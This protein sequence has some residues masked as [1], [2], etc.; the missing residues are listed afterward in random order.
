MKEATKFQKIQ[1]IFVSKKKQGSDDVENESSF[2]G[3]DV[4]K[5]PQENDNVALFHETNGHEMR[6]VEDRLENSESSRKRRNGEERLIVS[7]ISLDS[8]GAA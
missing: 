2:Q 3:S 6:F 4:I 7:M 1:F 8:R 5:P